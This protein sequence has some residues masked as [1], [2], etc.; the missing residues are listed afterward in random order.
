MR[1]QLLDAQGHQL[2]GPEGMLVNNVV[3]MS[4]F[5]TLWSVAI[6]RDNNVYIGINGSGAG[7]LAYVHKIS[8]RNSN[9]GAPMALAQVRVLM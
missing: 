2:F 5:T 4:T 3:P 1:L 9:F 7:N 6:D 8:P